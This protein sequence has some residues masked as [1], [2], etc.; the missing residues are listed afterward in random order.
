VRWDASG[1]AATELGDLGTDGAGQTWALAFGINDAGTAVGYARKYVDGAYMGSR[2]VRWDASGT[3]ATELGNLG[4][5]ASGA[6]FA[7]ALHINPAGTAVG[8]AYKYVDGTFM[9]DVAVRWEAA[10]TA[11]T[12]LGN[13]GT[14]ASG[15]AYAY[16]EAMNDAGTVVGGSGKYVGAADMGIRAVRWDASGTAA[17]EL[18]NLGTDASGYAE[19]WAL[20]INNAGAAVGFAGLYVGGTYI[21]Q[22][23]VYWGLDGAAVDLSDLIDPS[24]GWTLWSATDISDTDWITGWGSFDPD[25]PG[26]LD[27]Y[28]RAFL[29]QIPEPC[30][31]GL[32]SAAALAAM[33]SRR[34]FGG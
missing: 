8:R 34:R 20:A 27:A 18:G 19:G 15:Q 5:D 25:G 26:G 33:L 24:G 16:P 7:E 28:P 10:G 29:L 6:A 17:T 13:L 32:L 31:L 30:T 3:A 12:E 1:T 2:A 4:T 23:A 21:G 22:R 14:D 11:A 9:G